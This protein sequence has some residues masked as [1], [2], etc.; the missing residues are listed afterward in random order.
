MEQLRLSR[1][2]HLL[3]PLLLA[4]CL[5]RP[6][7]G[8]YPDPRTGTSRGDWLGLQCPPEQ[9]SAERN[10]RSL[11]TEY[12]GPVEI[13]LEIWLNHFYIDLLVS[14]VFG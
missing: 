4:H 10:I 3:L 7:K 13:R 1:L 12:P 6:I 11:D 9:R 14:F 5:L 8:P 2:A